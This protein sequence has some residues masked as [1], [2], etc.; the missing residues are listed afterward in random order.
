M[1]VLGWTRH[2]RAPTS[3]LRRPGSA[4]RAVRPQFPPLSGHGPAVSPCGSPFGN[5]EAPE[6]RALASLALGVVLW[7]P[8]HLCFFCSS[9]NLKGLGIRSPAL[10][11]AIE[12]G[13]GK[14][15]PQLQPYLCFGRATES[16]ALWAHRPP[17]RGLPS[18]SCVALERWL[19]F[20]DPIGSSLKWWNHVNDPI[21]TP[22]TVYQVLFKSCTAFFKRRLTSRKR[23][24]WGEHREEGQNSAVKDSNPKAHYVRKA[25][26]PLP[27]KIH[28]V[29]LPR[30]TTQ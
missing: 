5:L 24:L 25:L 13:D 21:I 1:E 29:A 26:T 9:R 16:S 18:A 2:S 15:A 11:P 6:G 12:A 10:S 3:A 28:R 19:A 30:C 7:P 8:A 14:S 4:L 17:R 27:W 23:P 22:G 20:S